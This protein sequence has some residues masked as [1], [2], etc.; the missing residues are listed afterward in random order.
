MEMDGIAAAKALREVNSTAVLCY[1][2]GFVEYAPLGYRVDAFRYLMKKD[3]DG[4]FADCMDEIVVKL[5][6][7]SKRIPVVTT[8]GEQ[9]KLVSSLM[10]MEMLHFCWS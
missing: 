5:E 7:S 1:V 9:S 2:S 6:I 3:L 10:I 8:E 4:S